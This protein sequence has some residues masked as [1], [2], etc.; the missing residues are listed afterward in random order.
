MLLPNRFITLLRI[1]NPKAT[2]RT[3]AFA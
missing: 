1:I 3:A 2:Y